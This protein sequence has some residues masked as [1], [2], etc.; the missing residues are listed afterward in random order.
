MN[1]SRNPDSVHPPL[2]AYMHT[3]K[4]PAA[5]EWLVVSG[6]VGADAGGAVA[7]GAKA[8]SVQALRNILACLAAQGMGAEDLVKITV[9]LTDSRFV[10]DFREARA[11]VFG[12]SVKPTSTL[13]IIA[14]LAAPE[15]LVEVEAWAA[16]G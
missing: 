10:P 12:E 15:L 11:E 9:Y 1:T 3:V 5:A 4:V 13:L 7:E 8:Q 6:Q 2:G 16:K 14:G